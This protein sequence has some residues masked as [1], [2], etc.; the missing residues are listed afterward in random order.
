MYAVV[1]ALKR[2]DALL[3]GAEIEIVSDHNPL[4]YLTQNVSRGTKLT[5]WALAFAKVQ[6]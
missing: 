4:A 5:R 1:W 3:Y 6:V 2:F